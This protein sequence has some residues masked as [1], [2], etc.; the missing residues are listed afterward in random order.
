M[1]M[2]TKG[3]RRRALRILLVDDDPDA[4]ILTRDL[5]E[6]SGRTFELE[7]E[8]AY[9]P[10][11]RA[12]REGHYD[13]CLFD[14][15][16]GAETGLSLV[17]AA[18]EQ[19]ARAPAIL[20]T[21]QDDRAIDEAAEAVGA[22]GYLTKGNLTAT[23]LERSIRYAVRN[24]RRTDELEALASRDPMTGLLNVR[25]FHQRLRGAVERAARNDD[26][27][28][29][30]FLDL[31]KFKP[32]NDQYGHQIG[33]EVLQ[34]VARRLEMALRTIDHIGRL[35]GDEF[36]VVLDTTVNTE[37]ARNVAEKLAATI[38]DPMLIAGREFTIG[39][40]IG[41]ALFP[42][43][44]VD[45]MELLAAADRAMYRAKAGEHRV[46]FDEV[47]DVKMPAERPKANT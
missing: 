26:Q 5:L 2:V 14:Y 42:D 10:G 38:C 27:V 11:L 34:T 9:E 25:G 47:A 20:L 8:S 37:G 23:L 1:S 40:S 21:G 6:E 12:M 16:L 17:K 39:V 44:A 33:D 4:E 29:V 43:S 19:G 22:V 3:D 35:G 41:V 24:R 36:G 46:A 30:L 28:A 7:W 18:R 45:P 31:D 15:R 13:V 32:I